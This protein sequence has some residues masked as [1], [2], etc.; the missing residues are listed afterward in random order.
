MENKWKNQNQSESY[1]CKDLKDSIERK[2]Y[3]KVN[4]RMRFG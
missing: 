4:R 2:A 1:K 3:M